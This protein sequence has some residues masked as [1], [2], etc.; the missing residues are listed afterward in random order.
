MT[1]PESEAKRATRA[2]NSSS[3]NEPRSEGYAPITG[4]NNDKRYERNI[5][6]SKADVGSGSWWFIDPLVGGSEL[7]G[8]MSRENISDTDLIELRVEFDLFQRV[9]GAVSDRLGRVFR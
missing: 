6:G 9:K 8:S 4:G 2:S 3:N 7:G 5:S 1:P